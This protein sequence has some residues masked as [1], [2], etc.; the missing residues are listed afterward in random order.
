M[1]FKL[2]L[3][4]LFFTELIIAQ[5]YIS[6]KVDWESPVV[7]NGINYPSFKGADFNQDFLP[8]YNK[9]IP[10]RKG[11][12]EV[13]LINLVFDERAI[14]VGEGLNSDLIK[15]AKKLSFN[16]FT[17]NNTTILDVNV[18]PLMLNPKTNTLGRLLSFDISYKYISENKSA[19]M[20]RT[21]ASSSLLN[22][23]EWV[24]L[25]LV[26]TGVYKI[27]YSDLVSYG[28]SNPNNVRIYG[29]GGA[30][31][32]EKN[33]KA[34][35]DDMNELRIK[36]Y[37]GADGLFNDGDYILFY[38]EGPETWEYNIYKEQFEHSIHHYSDTIFYYVSSGTGSMKS[39]AQINQNTNTATAINVFLD[40]QMIENNTTSLLH[41]G[42]DWF[43]KEFNSINESY[44]YSF[45][46]ANLVVDSLVRIK[47][48]C[49]ARYSIPTNLDLFY[50]EKNVLSLK[51]PEVYLSS[52]SGYY[53]RK[54][55]AYN[56]FNVTSA[57]FM[58]TAKYNMYQQANAWMDYIS[59]NAVR[60]LQMSESQL[61][62]GNIYNIGGVNNYLISNVSSSHL[63][64]DI[65]EL[66]NIS[67]IKS[68]FSN[69]KISF[70]M[71][72]DNVKEYI[73]FKPSD[74]YSILSAHKIN[75]QNLHGLKNIE[76]VIL[77][78][79]DFKR[80]ALQIAEFHTRES[81]LN[82]VVVTNEEVY[83]EFSS[84]IADVTAIKNF[85]RHLYHHRS[86]TDTLKYLMLL[87]DGSYDNKLQSSSNSNYILTY[88]SDGSVR[89]NGTFVCDDY[90]GLLDDN[91]GA[92][93]G[94]LD[95]GIGRLVV[96]NTAEADNSVKKILNYSKNS[97]SYGSWRSL[98]NFIADNGDDN[99]HVED[100]D[101]IATMV[102]REY[103]YFNL[104][105][106]Y[107]DAYPLE[108]SA[109]GDVVPEETHDFNTA[110]NQGTLILSYS[111]HGGEVGWAH[112]RILEIA[113][114]SNWDNFDNMPVFVTATCE[115]S[116]FDDP[117]RTSAGELVILNPNGGGLALFTTSRA[118]FGSPN[119]NLNR[120]LYENAFRK[121]DGKFP[122]MGDILM[123]S[124]QQSGSDNNGKKFILL[125]D[126][127]QRMVYPEY[128]VIATEINYNP[129]SETPDTISAL[130]QVTI[131][132]EVLDNQ[133]NKM[134]EF[135]GVI[136]T[137]VF[138]KP[139][140]INT[141]GNDGG[142]SKRFSIQKSILYKG[143][144]TVE[145]GGFELT[146][147]VPKD[148]AYQYGFGKISFYSCNGT[149]D[150]NGYYKN[151]M[152][153]GY[154]DTV[155]TDDIGPEIRLFINNEYFV[156]G[157]ITDENPVLLALVSDE[158]GINTV[159]NGIGHDITAILDGNTDDIR[160]LN[161]YY[162]SDLNTFKSGSV[163][164]PFFNLSQGHH[165]IV[166]KVWDVF[167]NSSEATISF[168]VSLSGEFVFEDLLNYPNP[169]SEYTHFTFSH[170]QTEQYL[171]VEINIFALTGQFVTQLS[172]RI[173]ANGYKP[174]PIIW[175]GKD[176]KGAQVSNGEYIYTI[177]LRNEKGETSQKSEKLIISRQNQ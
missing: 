130:S 115:F 163:T 47:S 83:N 171:D 126:P 68:T 106:I 64:W 87:G 119:Y 154:D 56:S 127:A 4:F 84:G 41:S 99:L 40:K 45:S 61:Q 177:H 176:A 66:E 3:L 170:N 28:I 151:L 107:I 54:A 166:F 20:H 37:N 42:K 85:M 62:F 111:G 75:N 124:K 123:L 8:V 58:L 172:S 169:F 120:R 67:E 27:S 138:D 139:I 18:I 51:V 144:T 89:V 77:T 133:G 141:Q 23:G 19:L 63:V 90:F 128:N 161:D 79:R 73:V 94:Y 167:N 114:I 157:G 147:V 140:T 65:S 135:D 95:I 52:A 165:S 159:G 46:F 13:E 131:K 74:T 168:A 150:A 6:S 69:N 34:M 146:F 25:G 16:V 80:Q 152:I 156:E 160:V 36:F 103:P 116:R 145:E 92:L 29:Y 102:E 101:E 175:D 91:E 121:I 5:T 1:K 10:V 44:N 132:G 149:I 98:I 2:L 7:I 17:K 137:T 129:V 50:K 118:T 78:H 96:K 71:A 112:E 110:V 113:D 108:E 35:P 142:S 76:Y 70:K 97:K 9:Q 174:E 153:G 32:P 122:T 109:G 22:K 43:G 104:N 57:N 24:K 72:A 14:N 105:K 158:N 53:A 33:N 12:H 48:S 86:F 38:A 39:I 31:L 143:K 26:N 88:Q 82:T 100:A 30:V 173:Y 136:F 117:E 11:N 162:E 15:K 148:I 55:S 49:A 155:V 164:F 134:N 21:N 81:G 93:S 59:V 125:G 60:K